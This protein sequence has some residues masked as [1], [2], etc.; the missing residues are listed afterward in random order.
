MFNIEDK[1]LTEEEE[2]PET[3]VTTRS[4]NSLKEDNMILPKIKKLQENMRKIKNNT[5]TINIRE[6]VI[7]SQ[8]PKKVNMPVKSTENKAEN[9]KKNSTKHEMGYYIVEDIKKAKA[10]ISLFE[11]CNLPQQKKNLLKALETPVKEPQND[12][13]PEEEIGEASLGGNSKYRT[14][15][16]LLTFEIF[17][18]NVHNC[19]VE[20]GSSVIV[21]PR[22]ICKQING[23]TKPTTGQVLQ[24]DRT[25]VKVIG[26]MEDVLI[27]LS[28]DERVC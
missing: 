6:F 1:D 21:M 2:I 12:N 17:N 10:N 25:T 5:Q 23:Q 4:Q 27:R 13:Q 8:I 20:S 15:S 22:S 14:P 19:L 9:V 18:Y 24:L 3:N 28:A 16:F 11:M 7:T 26:E